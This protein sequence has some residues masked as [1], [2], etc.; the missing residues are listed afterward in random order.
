M[1][2]ITLVASGGTF[3][4]TFNG[5]TTAAIP[6]NASAVQVESALNALSDIGGVGGTVSVALTTSGSITIYTI[7]F[8]GTMRNQNEPAISINTQ[9]LTGSVSGSGFEALLTVGQKPAWS[10]N[11]TE[12]AVPAFANNTFSTF[13]TNGIAIF[14][15][16]GALI[17]FIPEVNGVNGVTWTPDGE[18][19]IYSAT[20]SS[21]SSI[22]GHDLASGQEWTID[23]GS[24]AAGN[25]LDPTVA[26]DGS[27]IAFA[28]SSSPPS[29]WTVDLSGANPK[30]L[31]TSNST[32]VDNPDWQP[33]PA[34]KTFVGTGGAIGTSASG[35]LFGQ[36]VN[37][38]GSLLVFT[39]ATPS[40]VTV[41]SSG[42]QQ[43]GFI[44][45][46]N[47]FTSM[48]YTNAYYGSQVSVI[49]G[50]VSSASEVLVMF[51]LNN[52]TI[53]GV[54]T[55]APSAPVAA[56]KQSAGVVYTGK[57]LQVWDA[58][59]KLVAPSGATRIETDDAKGKLLFR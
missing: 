24:A 53:S 59:G 33:Y 20:V 51:N 15:A 14:G 19:L 50:S 2:G 49:P 36:S 42:L 57:F 12:I 7:T 39:A 58:R 43:T 23:T 4:L 30:L 21:T 29:I 40:S 37:G 25:D 55:I 26:P 3:T 8:T 35:F 34:K 10:S 44:L 46:A 22:F 13:T 41:T 32:G 47:N 9:G 45:K 6:F 31:V 56:V 17:S 54:A 27:T 48:S 11:G 28:R 38:F 5:E 18:K 52:G 16:S 1:Q